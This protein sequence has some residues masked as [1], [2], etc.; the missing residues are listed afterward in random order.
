MPRPAV[1]GIDSDEEREQCFAQLPVAAAAWVSRF[2]C[3]QT[4]PRSAG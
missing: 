4:P 1:F 2:A 3:A